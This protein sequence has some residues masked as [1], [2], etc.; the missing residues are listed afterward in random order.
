MD[1]EGQKNKGQNKGQNKGHKSHNQTDPTMQTIHNNHQTI[2]QAAQPRIQQANYY[3][4][5][6]A[7]HQRQTQPQ[8]GGAIRKTWAWQAEAQPNPCG[9]RHF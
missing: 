5:R 4:H 2:G 9:T 6:G 1:I 8:W 7:F 3:Q